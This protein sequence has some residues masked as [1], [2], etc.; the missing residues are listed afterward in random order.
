MSRRARRPRTGSVSAAWSPPTYSDLAAWFHGGAGV[1]VSTAVDSWTSQTAIPHVVGNTGS[2]RPTFTASGQ[3]GMPG[4]TLASASSQF[5]FD[6]SSTLAGILDGT[7]PFS[8]F[9]VCT[10]TPNGA[11]QATWSIG[12]SGSTQHAFIQRIESTGADNTFRAA[13][14]GLSQ[15]GIIADDALPVLYRSVFN[16][17]QSNSHMNGV[18]SVINYANAASIVAN[19]FYIGAWRFNGATGGL[20]NGTIYEIIIYTRTLSQAETAQV[21]GYLKAKYALSAPGLYPNFHRWWRGDSGITL[22]VGDVSAWASKINTSSSVTNASAPSQ[23][24][25]SATSGGL[26]NSRASVQYN[27]SDVLG[28]NEAVANWKW[29]HDGT[30]DWTIL[31]PFSIISTG[32]SRQMFITSGANAVSD[33]IFVFTTA[34]NNVQ[35]Q[36]ANNSGVY[37]ADLTSTGG[38]F[39]GGT[40]KWIALR[41]RRNQDFALLWSGGNSVSMALVGTPGTGTYQTLST[42]FFDQYVPEIL[43]WKSALSDDDI[44]TLATK[45]LNPLLGVTI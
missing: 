28:S 29:I 3:N 36:I 21:E 44:T 43:M 12:D 6:S 11:P 13:G 25:F 41:Y 4:V 5:L 35:A 15:T 9:V 33:G 20:F 45:Y 42:R 24:L 7:Q 10:R 23:P 17:T 31:V 37:H 8:A 14:V 19:R 39:T 22:N 2:N 34:G 38:A 18:P 27:P 1:S 30:T 40:Q 26:F 32:V 16:G